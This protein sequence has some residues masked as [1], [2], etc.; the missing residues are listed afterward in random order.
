MLSY[1]SFIFSHL[2]FGVHLE[3]F[4]KFITFLSS[5]IIS[6]PMP[7]SNHVCQR[8]VDYINDWLFRDSLICF[9]YLAQYILYCLG[10]CSIRVS[11]QVAY[12]SF[13]D[14][15]F[16]VTLAS[17]GFM[18]LH[19]SCGLQLPGTLTV[20]MLNLEMKSR[21]N[22]ILAIL[23]LPAHRCRTSIFH[24]CSSFTFYQFSSFPCII[25]LDLYTSISLWRVPCVQFGLHFSW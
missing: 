19:M 15:S 6:V 3:L 21:R 24:P 9:L 8:S 5:V 4:C 10:Y 17:L 1:R 18:A 2:R 13:S 23:C 14:L 25:L 12:D 7:L 22:N 20:I 16:N 11:I